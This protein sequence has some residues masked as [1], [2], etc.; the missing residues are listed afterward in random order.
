MNISGETWYDPSK[1]TKVV[2]TDLLERGDTDLKDKEDED[3]NISVDENVTEE[4]G[5]EHD[6]TDVEENCRLF[7]SRG[8]ANTRRS[9]A[10][11]RSV[12]LGVTK[13][14]G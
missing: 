10:L 11:L 14:K 5:D 8:A 12:V 2:V 13:Y 1:Q 4:G 7:L 9:S 6:L 3:N